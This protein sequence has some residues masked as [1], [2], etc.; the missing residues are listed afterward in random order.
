WIIRALRGESFAIV[1][2]PGLGKTTFG[3]I[4]S[5]YFASKSQ[6][7]LMMF[8]TKTL[9]SQVVQK[10]QEMSKLLDQPPRVLYYSSGITRSKKAEFNK[11][12]NERDFDVLISTSRYVMENLDELNKIKYRYL[13]IDDVDAVLKSSKS[14]ITILKLMGF[15]DDNIGKARELLRLSRDDKSSFEEI[16]KIRKKFMGERITIFSSA[17]ITKS[18]PVFTSLVGFKPG[19]ATIYLRNVIDSF[20][21]EENPV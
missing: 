17:T 5:L 1:A 10:I 21:V 15:N 7:S 8:P 19:S 14:S 16:R 13:F 3:I 20:V 9:V 2:P 11:S 18:N 4:M 12:L 6:K